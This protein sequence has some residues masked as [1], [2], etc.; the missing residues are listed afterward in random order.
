MKNF[1]LLLPLLFIAND[2]SANQFSPRT[3]CTNAPIN[4]ELQAPPYFAFN[5]PERVKADFT[6]SFNERHDVYFYTSEDN[7][8]GSNTTDVWNNAYIN[9]EFNDGIEGIKTI[10]AREEVDPRYPGTCHKISVIA[11]NLPQILS[12]KNSGE[13]KL[14]FISSA[15]ISNY[16]KRS[17]ENKGPLFTYHLRNIDYNTYESFST[18]S[19]KIDF[20]PKYRGFY[21]I[22]LVVSDGVFETQRVL[23]PVYYKNGDTPQDQFG[24]DRPIR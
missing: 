6:F 20:Y 24:K 11:Q 13:E 22:V 17:K 8:I 15:K 18:E 1:V 14:S 2:L 5:K 16:S 19:Y 23:T 7:Y 9:I 4:F 3:D 10:W 21:H 12:A